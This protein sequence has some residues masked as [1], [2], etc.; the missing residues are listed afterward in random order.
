[1]VEGQSEDQNAFEDHLQ[2]RTEKDVEVFDQVRLNMDRVHENESHLRRI[3][4]TKC[5]DIWVNDLALKKDEGKARPRKAWCS[6]APSWGQHPLRTY[7]FCLTPRHG[8]ISCLPLPSTL[9]LFIT[10]AT[11]IV[12]L[13]LS[14]K[15]EQDN[16]HIGHIM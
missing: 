12:M 6:F 5:F 7:G 11:V 2:A 14:A 15:K 8:S 16:Y 10:S 3:K 9:Q 13:S 1:M 4:R